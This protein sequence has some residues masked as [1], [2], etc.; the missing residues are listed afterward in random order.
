M[1]PRGKDMADLNKMDRTWLCSVVFMDIANYSS[2]SVE[3]QMKWKQRFNGYLTEAIQNVPESERVILD[4]GD[5]AAICFLGAPEAAMFAALQLSQSFVLDERNYRPGLSVRLGINLGPVKLVKDINGALNAIGDGINAGQRI[6][7]F[8]SANKIL[9]SQSFFEVVSRLSDDYKPLFHLKGIETDKHIREHTV[10]HLDPPSAEKHEPIVA[11]AEGQAVPSIP[12]IS[13]TVAP[14]GIASGS[15]GSV[16]PGPEHRAPQNRLILWLAGGGVALVV[17]AA[18]LAWRIYAPAASAKPNSNAAPVAQNPTSAAIQAPA[19]KV[20][21]VAPPPVAQAVAP[22]TVPPL[23]NTATLLAPPDKT[24]AIKPATEPIARAQTARKPSLPPPVVAAA[25]DPIKLLQDGKTQLAD[26]KEESARESFRKAADAGN[27]QAT[28][29]LG[30]LYAQG[31]GGPKSDSDAAHMFRQAADLGNARGM[32][33][34]GLMYEAGRVAPAGPD[35]RAAAHWYTEASNRGDRDAAYRLGVMYEEGRG[36][37][38]D[39]NE[40][41]RLYA[42]AGTPDA[43]MRRAKLPPE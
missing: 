14:S 35:N 9:V 6:M 11:N 16:A 31:L 30:T 34:L 26:H 36:V 28:V 24:P 3:L 19:A 25:P 12:E 29:L 7:S 37:T 23:Q 17:V 15:V 13:I 42:K 40:A 1:E 38:K 18:A 10:Y 20:P 2:Q 43:M 5:G 4:T 32:Y 39:L 27:A 8:A 33:N 21:D 41:R 22:S